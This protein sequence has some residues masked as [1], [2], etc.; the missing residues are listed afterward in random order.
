M[1]LSYQNKQR[2]LEASTLQERYEVLMELL[3]KETDIMRIKNELQR[4]VK[5]RVDKNRKNISCGN[6]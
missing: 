4:K 3:M 5:E 2:L 6:R 1:P